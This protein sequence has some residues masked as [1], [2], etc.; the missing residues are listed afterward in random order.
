MPKLPGQYCHNEETQTHP[1]RAPTSTPQDGAQ[2]TTA[3]SPSLAPSSLSWLN[4]KAR[5]PPS[6]CA[7]LDD[8]PHGFPTTHC[9]STDTHAASK[10]DHQ[11]NQEASTS[12][13]CRHHH[14]KPPSDPGEQVQDRSI[15]YQA[16]TFN[17]CEHQP[18]PVMDGPP[19][20]LMIDPTP[21]RLPTIP[22]FPFH[23]IG[24]MKLRLA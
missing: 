24:R 1:Q 4:H 3:R 23:S 7:D 10:Q 12:C 18:L 20:R 17:T 22:P 5:D 13:P 8:H 15:P 14:P 2:P 21:H 11:A 6:R 16:S 19:M 9:D